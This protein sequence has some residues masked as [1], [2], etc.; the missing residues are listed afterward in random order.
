MLTN[1]CITSSRK[2]SVLNYDVLHT[3]S[4]LLSTDEL[5]ASVTI[6]NITAYVPKKVSRTVQRC[7]NEIEGTQMA[8]QS[9]LWS[10][11]P[12]HNEWP[13]QTCATRHSKRRQSP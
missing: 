5:L 4:A 9:S 2:N 8:R 3:Y 11:P 10:S 1:V 13:S 12:L 7:L 6:P